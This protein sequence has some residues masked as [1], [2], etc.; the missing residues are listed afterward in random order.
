MSG[1]PEA[2]GAAQGA[3]QADGE[4]ATFPVGASTNAADG[5]PMVGAKL[6]LAATGA[7]QLAIALSHLDDV[8][9]VAW[10]MD[11]ALTVSKGTVA[12]DGS[13]ELEPFT[14][15]VMVMFEFNKLSCQAGPFTAGKLD[16]FLRPVCK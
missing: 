12:A 2:S 13:L 5:A 8:S 6:V 14:A 9:D 1:M 11:K 7:P 15:S 3:G 4:S 10:H 16:A